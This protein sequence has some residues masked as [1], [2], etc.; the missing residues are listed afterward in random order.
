MYV[1]SSPSP[2]IDSPSSRGG[3]SGSVRPSRISRPFSTL[4]FR[5]IGAVFP[6]QWSTILRLCCLFD[7]FT[8][9]VELCIYDIYTRRSQ[10]HSVGKQERQPITMRDN[11]VRRNSS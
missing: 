8:L 2:P 3:G 10:Y 1:L 9:Y 11:K 4:H 7:Y 5:T 6:L